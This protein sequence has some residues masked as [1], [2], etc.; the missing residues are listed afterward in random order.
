MAI[1]I[2]NQKQVMARS[3]V[4]YRGVIIFETKFGCEFFIGFKKYTKRNL[5]E[6]TAFIDDK[7]GGNRV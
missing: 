3:R 7:L 2:T 6:A 1:A 5:V 4:I